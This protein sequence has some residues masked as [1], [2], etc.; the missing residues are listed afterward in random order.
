MISGPWFISFSVRWVRDWGR[1]DRGAAVRAG[2]LR[3]AAR[4]LAASAALA[5]SAG[6]VAATPPTPAKTLGLTYEVYAGGLHIFTFDL[7]LVLEPTG[8][9]IAAEGSTRGMTSVLYKWDVK[10]AAE[11]EAKPLSGKSGIAERLRPARYVTVNTGRQQ[12]KTMQLAFDPTGSFSVVRNPP[13]GGDETEDREDLPSKLPPDI[14]DPLSAALVATQNLAKTGL[15]E[16]TIPVF[17]G[18]RRYN[19]LLHDS[20]VATVPKS[21]TSVYDGP[22]TLCSFTM[23]RISGFSKKKRRYA[24]QWDEDKDEPPTLWVA[25]VRDDMPPVPVRFTGAISFGSIVVHLIRVEAGSE[26]ASTDPR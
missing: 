1:R 7:D 18:K 23:E 13:D 17:D 25:Q 12:P 6:T 9:R 10:L 16:Q 11:G 2:R 15:C 21:R 14:V 19:L 20:G 26:I 8:Y 22:A 5:L 4:A 3:T 24:N